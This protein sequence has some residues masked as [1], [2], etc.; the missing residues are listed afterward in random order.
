MK[1]F[2]LTWGISLNPLQNGNLMNIPLADCEKLL[3]QL[4]KTSKR[5]YSQIVAAHRQS[6]QQVALWI[7][8]WLSQVW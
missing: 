4:L 6:A 2:L 8:G 3:R 5:R 1:I 7:S